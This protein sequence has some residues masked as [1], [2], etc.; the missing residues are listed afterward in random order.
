MLRTIQ[1]DD[2]LGIEA[3]EIGDVVSQ[4]MLATK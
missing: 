1:L 4:W 3:G 2:Y